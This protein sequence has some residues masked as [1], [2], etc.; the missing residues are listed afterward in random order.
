MR[1]SLGAREH[2]VGELINLN[3]SV[4]LE[5]VVL[6][7]CDVVLQGRSEIEVRGSLQI[8]NCRI[9]MEN[10]RSVAAISNGG[11]ATI[12]NCVVMNPPDVQCE[13][14]GL[15]YIFRHPPT[16]CPYSVIDVVMNA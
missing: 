10:G 8:S 13:E 9:F 15:E 3:G 1:F 14:C 4:T 6:V 5:D 12:T 7:D 16:D 11:H 2:I